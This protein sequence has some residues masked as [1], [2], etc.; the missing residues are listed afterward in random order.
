MK[1]RFTWLLIALTALC[2][3]FTAACDGC[4]A[5]PPDD[6]DRTSTQEPVNPDD[7]GN[8]T[9]DDSGNETPDDSGSETPDDSDSGTTDDSQDGGSTE[10]TNPNGPIELP[11]KPV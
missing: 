2:L 3:C 8:E 4:N 10:E 9:P 7:G 11:E 1:K 5:T 6:S